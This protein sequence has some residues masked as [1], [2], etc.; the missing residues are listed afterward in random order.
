MLQENIE[1]LFLVADINRTTNKYRPAISN[2]LI[3]LSRLG[4]FKQTLIS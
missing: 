2:I 3:I 4:L 1:P